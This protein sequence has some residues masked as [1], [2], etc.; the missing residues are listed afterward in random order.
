VLFEPYT[1]EA[2]AQTFDWT[3]R[4]GIFSEGAMGRGRYEDAVIR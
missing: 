1:K 4:H 3:T 2:H